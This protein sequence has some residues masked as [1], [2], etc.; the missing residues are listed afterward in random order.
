[1]TTDNPGSS[2]E[3]AFALREFALAA[4]GAQQQ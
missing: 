1:V 3:F 2:E 4:S